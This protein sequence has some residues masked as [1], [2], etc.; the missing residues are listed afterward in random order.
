MSSMLLSTF[1]PQ[2]GFS[3]LA[4][5][6]AGFSGAA[7]LS[8]S[9]GVELCHNLTLEFDKSNIDSLPRK[10]VLSTLEG[11]GTLWTSFCWLR[12]AIAYLTSYWRCCGVRS[13]F[14]FVLNRSLLFLSSWVRGIRP[15]QNAV[16]LILQLPWKTWAR[17]ETRVSFKRFYLVC[18]AAL[19]RTDEAPSESQQK[20]L[21]ITR[22]QNKCHVKSASGKLVPRH[23]LISGAV[24]RQLFVLVINYVNSCCCFFYMF[25]T[26]GKH[27]IEFLLVGSHCHLSAS[28]PRCVSIQVNGDQKIRVDS[29]HH[30]WSAVTELRVTFWSNRINND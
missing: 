28:L 4:F 18:W 26:K 17:S 3:Q 14:F 6:P 16:T 23:L 20:W 5:L 27:R 11:S 25:A 29:N 15:K 1:F 19:Q 7:F 22:S 10:A 30:D 8:H 24:T 21:G 13:V 9:V 2:T 12:K